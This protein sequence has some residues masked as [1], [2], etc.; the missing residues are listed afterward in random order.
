MS[1][2]LL[3]H[4]A[5]GAKDQLRPLAQSLED[6]YEVHSLSFSGHGGEPFPSAFSI[7]IFA[8]DVLGWLNNERIGAIDIFGYSMGGYVALYLAKYYPDR[9]GKVFTL[10][11][12]FHWDEATAQKEVKMLEPAKIEEKIPSFAK[13]LEQRHQ[14]NDW[15][16]V[17]SA[18]AQMMLEMGKDNP[19]KSDDYASITNEAMISI[20][21]RDKMVS[22]EETI[23]VYRQL[24]N[25]RLLVIPDTPHPLEQV[26]IDRLSS[27]VKSF[28]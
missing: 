28:F 9:I 14:P 24:K 21:D 4:G 25:A 27:E 10:A 15:K 13:A 7:K 26:S 8:E 17:M 1:R 11:T 3:L 22:L 23:A 5:I 20:G 12:K 2:L 18:T 19:L 16:K 6:N